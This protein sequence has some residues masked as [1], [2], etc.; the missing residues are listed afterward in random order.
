MI[1]RADAGVLVG[2]AGDVYPLLIGVDLRRVLL[3]PVERQQQRIRHLCR[4]GVYGGQ[5]CGVNGG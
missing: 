2:K 5:G 4:V 1:I 3:Q